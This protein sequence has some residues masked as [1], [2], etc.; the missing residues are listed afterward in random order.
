[1]VRGGIDISHGEGVLDAH[2]EKVVV[3]QKG[4]EWQFSKLRTLSFQIVTTPPRLPQ[5]SMERKQFRLRGRKCFAFIAERS[6]S[7]DSRIHT[8]VGVEEDWVPLTTV[9]F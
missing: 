3:R 8:I 4:E 7:L 5:V 2:R 1:M 9:H 6:Q